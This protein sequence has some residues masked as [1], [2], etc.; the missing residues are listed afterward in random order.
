MSSGEVKEE[1]KEI[2]TRLQPQC[3]AVMK[4]PI[5]HNIAL[6]RQ[7]IELFDENNCQ[8]LNPVVDYIALPLLMILRK[9]DT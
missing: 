2:F 3:V 4:A 8:Q 9:S 5:A 6:L 7:E 1:F